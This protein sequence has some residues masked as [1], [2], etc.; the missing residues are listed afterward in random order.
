M[1]TAGIQQRKNKMNTKL[2]KAIAS[3]LVA[4]TLAGC[5][6]AELVREVNTKQNAHYQV[7]RAA[8]LKNE[9]L[10][11]VTTPGLEGMPRSQNPGYHTTA[12][13]Q[14]TIPNER[15]YTEYALW[16]ACR[17]V[18]PETRAQMRQQAEHAGRDLLIGLTAIGLGVAAG[19]A[20]A[21]NAPSVP[22]PPGPPSMRPPMPH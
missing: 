16:K 2:E 22:G 8:V 7:A 17:D 12:N 6:P 11:E 9:S 5:A 3:A 4:T 21:H 14:Y 18:D 1:D 15:Y 13:G 10:C 20:L 19:A